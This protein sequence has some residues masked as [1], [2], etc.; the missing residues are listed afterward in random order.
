MKKISRFGGGLSL[1][2]YGY[3]KVSLSLSFSLFFSFTIITSSEQIPIIEQI[4]FPP[5]RGKD[6]VR[7]GPMG[8][9]K[10]VVGRGF[11]FLCVGFGNG[12]SGRE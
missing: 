3:I 10:G 8:N 9:L 12:K 7:D 2:F 6:L 1:E 11:E 4:Y 5:S